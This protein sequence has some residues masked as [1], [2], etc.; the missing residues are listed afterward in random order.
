MLDP[1]LVL[2]G[3]L[4]AGPLHA[5]EDLAK[6][7]PSTVEAS[8]AMSPRLWT[9]R[10]EDVWV[11]TSFEL[12]LQGKLKVETGKAELV[13]GHDGGNALWAVVLPKEPGSVRCEGPANGEA[14]SSIYLR[15]HPSR[16]GEFFPSQT[17]R[18]HGSQLAGLDGRRIFGT[19]INGSWQSGGRPVVPTESS[20]V[21]DLETDGGRRFFLLD[22]EKG[23]VKYE[24]YFER[25]PVRPSAPIEP[26]NAAAEFD[27]VWSAFDENYAGF[28]LLPGLDWE[29]AGERWRA[30]AER[31][32]TVHRLG[33]ALTGLLEE[34]GDLHAWVA[35]GVE[36]LPMERPLRPLNGSFKACSRM[37][38]GLKDTK[39]DLAWGRTTDGIGYVNVYSLSNS[40]LPAT[41][42]AVLEELAETW[43]LVVDLRFN[44]GG[45]ELLGR[46]IA[47]RLLE[48]AVVY[49]KNRYRNG[50]AHDDLGPV[51]DRVCEPRGPWRY[52]APLV[53]LW[54]RRTMSS[55]ESMGLMLA[56][57]PGAVTMGDN[58]AGSSG[59]PM[60][61]TLEGGVRVNLPR[62]LD[63]DPEGR[64]IEHVGV[65]PEIRVEAEPAEFT[66]EADPVLAAALARLRGAPEEE[67]RAGRRE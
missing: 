50:A 39:K 58:T 9:S 3:L 47:G 34:L 35:V 13:I 64:P 46:E 2:A 41:F 1:R 27:V 40:E 60:Q 62:W 37:V 4:L 45:N 29:E 10:A 54:G 18:G 7:Y 24:P 31:A 11:L 52:E 28:G 5:F 56:Q 53:I 19:K 44:G 14:V 61:L 25:F 38:S 17:V 32:T 51:L 57:V 55:A 6:V 8:P 12:G 66:N 33:G 23:T 49:S 20:V 48:E 65:A 26:E 43:A 30:V 42:D 15:F 67:R 63:L 21:V 59:N 22:E 16:V 36:F